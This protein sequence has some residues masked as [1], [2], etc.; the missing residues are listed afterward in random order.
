MTT[1]TPLLACAFTLMM[2]APAP[3]AAYNVLKTFNCATDGCQPEAGLTVGPGQQLYG[4]TIFGSVYSIDPTGAPFANLHQLND[5]PEGAKPAARLTRHAGWLY[6]VA[7][8]GGL[9]P[10]A[11]GHGTIYRMDSGGNLQWLHQFSGADGSRPLGQLLKVTIAGQTFFYGTTMAGGTGF[12]TLFKFDPVSLSIVASYNFAAPSDGNAPLTG[13]T[14]HNNQ[15]YGTTSR[16]GQNGVG[17]LFSI[18]LGLSTKTTLH[19]F[20][21]GPTDGFNPSTRLIVV[22]PNGVMYGA[23]R[24]GGQFGNGTLYR[25]NSAT[26]NLTV[27]HSFSGAPGDGHTPTGDLVKYAGKVYGATQFGGTFDRG[28][29]FK[30]DLS[31]STMTLL[32]QFG[33][34][35]IDGSFPTSGLMEYQGLL[36]GTTSRSPGTVFS[37]LP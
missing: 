2:A 37:E 27:K 7:Q 8:A 1:F 36:Y 20:A 22:N 15:L 35:G 18:D 6:G 32:H 11:A 26:S 23:T 24:S 17:T 12:G 9:A 21:T 19:H 29:L 34:L 5:T 30:Y 33:S 25:F 28:A 16:G 13:L 10:G 31:L 14:L 3:A 4:P